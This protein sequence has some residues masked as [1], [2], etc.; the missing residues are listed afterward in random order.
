MKLEVS[1]GEAID[2]LSI[3]E[4]KLLKIRDEKKKTEIKKE[5]PNKIPNKI[6]LKFVINKIREI[7]RNHPH[8]DLLNTLLYFFDL[9]DFPSALAMVSLYLNKL[10]DTTK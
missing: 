7:E 1:I 3:L 9:I 4:I 10:Y 5:I 6:L 2:K 8:P